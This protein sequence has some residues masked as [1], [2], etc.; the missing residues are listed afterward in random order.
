MIDRSSLM[1]RGNHVAVG[2]SEGNEPRADLRFRCRRDHEVKAVREL[3]VDD[4]GPREEAALAIDLGAHVLT[5]RGPPN[6][7]TRDQRR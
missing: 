1:E 4:D 5:D 2:L 3:L 6:I 7:A